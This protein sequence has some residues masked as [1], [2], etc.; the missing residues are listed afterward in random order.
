MSQLSSL[1]NE[2]VRNYNAKRGAGDNYF[3]VKTADIRAIAKSIKSNP[4]LATELWN[5]GNIDA[6]L[7]ATLLM[8]P[9]QLSV[10]DLERLVGGINYYQVGDWL[11]TNV[12]KVHPQKE[13]MREKWMNSAVPFTA[14]MG[15]SLTTE[16]VIKDPAGLDLSG[17][18][19]RLE[20][21]MASAPSDAQWTM[22]YCL[23]E[24]GI[25]FPEYRERAV[26]I[27]EKI[28][29]FRDY[30]V[31]KGCVSPYAPIWISEMVSR[32]G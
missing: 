15:W 27:G 16:R 7:L 17:L 18:L 32:K 14:R 11:S 24:I 9:K 12:I 13:A 3:G 5:S 4:E 20:R 22:N 30:P 28:G 25:N 23:A 21:E 29:A 1:G 31:S 2:A 10:D 8:K 6:M 26:S 19:D